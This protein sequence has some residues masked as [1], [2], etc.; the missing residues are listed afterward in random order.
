MLMGMAARRA[1]VLLA[2]LG[3]GALAGCRSS[4]QTTGPGEEMVNSEAELYVAST[5]LWRPMSIPRVLG[6]P[7]SE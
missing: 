7:G 3:L 1:G 5:R 4:T 6:E 2:T